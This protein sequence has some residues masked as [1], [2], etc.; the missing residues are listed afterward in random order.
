MPR[1]TSP[2]S[3]SAAPSGRGRS[4]L[5][6]R[7]GFTLIE[8][9]VVLAI[10]ALLV[11]LL[12]PAVQ[13]IRAAAARVRCQNN[14]KQM[15]IAF[16]AHHDARG[17]FPKGGTHTPPASGANINFTTPQAR[18]AEWS[19]AYLI[20]PYIEQ[21][22]LYQDANS[23]TVRGTPIP[24][25]YCPSRRPAEAYNGR[26]K[27]DYAG[28]AGNHPDGENGMVMR[29]TCG[30][31]RAADVTDGLSHTVML[32]EKQLNRAAFGTA[33]DDNAS[34]CTPGWNG[35]W[36]VYRWG[37]TPPAPDRNVPGDISASHAFGSA[38]AGGFNCAFGD[39]SV[40]FIRYSV[41]PVTWERACV[42]NDNQ[43]I[44]PN[45]F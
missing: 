40:R 45:D 26:A 37:E 42:R 16:H 28:S 20:L 9:L 19:W 25:Y 3:A 39:G 6:G 44:N 21:N 41:S 13:K 38:H 27:I 18:E 31:V 35:D 30:V 11:G 15:G 17:H 8:V 7:V 14:L 29:T 2:P 1:S 4:G 36:E 43:A 10:L 24:I 23:A 22:D 33:I 32:G 5:R 12:L 34:Y